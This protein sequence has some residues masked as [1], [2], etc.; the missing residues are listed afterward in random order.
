MNTQTTTSNYIEAIKSIYSTYVNDKSYVF[1]SCDRGSTM[2]IMK[3]PEGHKNNEGRSSVVSQTHARHR[4][5]TMVV[6]VIF[7]KFYPINKL[8]SAKSYWAGIE[9]TYNLG[10]IS[11]DLYTDDDSEDS[12]GIYY[13]TSV[14]GAFYYDLI[15]AKYTG[16]FYDF[17]YNGR[18]KEHGMLVNGMRQGKWDEYYSNGQLC[19]LSHYT[20]DKLNGEYFEW[21]ENGN[22]SERC[23]YDNGVITGFSISWHENGEKESEGYYDEKGEKEGDWLHWNDDGT[24]NIFMTMNHGVKD[25]S[26]YEWK[27]NY[28]DELE[29]YSVYENGVLISK[30][31]L[32]S[33]E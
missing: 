15:A 30:D 20:D 29:S 13:C 9:T 31:G 2:L 10:P 14:E 3:K 24:R 5:D 27:P 1:K 8:E 17:H 18:V 33:S 28:L 6:E 23:F 19:T 25:G 7:D 11:P 21:Y 16:E 12:H 26:C 32:S 22:K 4:G